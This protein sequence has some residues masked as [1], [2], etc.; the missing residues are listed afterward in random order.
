MLDNSEASLNKQVLLMLSGGRDSFLSACRLVADEYQVMTVTYDNGCMSHAANALEVSKR[1]A[2]RFG[3]DRIRSV[4]IYTI[5]Q[6]LRPLLEDLLYL[7]IADICAE[8][9]HLLL[10]QVNCL[11]CH[12]IMYIHSI[13]Y[14]KAHSIQR[15]AVGARKQQQFFVELPEMKV[16]YEELCKRY[17]IELLLPVYDLQSDIQRKNELASWGFLPKSYEPQCWLGCPMKNSLTKEQCLDL[18]RYYEKKIAPLA[19]ENIAR[20]IPLKKMYYSDMSMEKGYV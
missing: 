8:Y 2:Q 6:D 7:D 20:L 3:D 19:D 14:C 13:A 10:S 16:H 18:N 5:A 4:G 11:A 1:L 15:M 9:P 17:G 12:T